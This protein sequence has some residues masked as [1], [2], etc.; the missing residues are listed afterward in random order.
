MDG[1][2][3]DR[4]RRSAGPAPGATGRRRLRWIAA[5]VVPAVVLIGITV[6]GTVPA[7]SQPG[8][9]PL[10]DPPPVPGTNPAVQ[11]WLNDQERLQIDLNNAL[12]TVQRLD[13]AAPDAMENCRRLGE[14]TAGLLRYRPA[15]DPRL[16]G[17]SRAGLE[18]FARAA[19]A[20]RT[21]DFA[22][23][24]RLVEEGLAARV[25]AQDDI[26]RILEGD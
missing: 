18:Q 17:P 24:K 8:P 25:P 14:L 16:T 22:T 2:D 10:P 19:A 26:D 20:C 4:D 5:V 7:A 1:A 9:P 3:A 12:L 13:P 11:R 23:A 6:L 21:R 15:P